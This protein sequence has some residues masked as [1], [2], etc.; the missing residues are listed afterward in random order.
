M[1]VALMQP[2]KHKVMSP[3]QYPQEREQPPAC[4]LS[5]GPVKWYMPAQKIA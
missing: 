3:P 1:R 2:L 5:S 4:L